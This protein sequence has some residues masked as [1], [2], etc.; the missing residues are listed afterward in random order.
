MIMA[1]VKVFEIIKIPTTTAYS[2]VP[3]LD[4]F[5][6]PKFREEFNGSLLNADRVTFA[7]NKI[8]HLSLFLK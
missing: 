5:N 3:R 6:N 7:L 2:L 1:W 8:I 4:Y